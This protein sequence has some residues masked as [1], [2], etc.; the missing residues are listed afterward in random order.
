MDSQART[1]IEDPLSDPRILSTKQSLHFWSS[2]GVSNSEAPKASFSNVCSEIVTFSE[3]W[4]MY[5]TKSLLLKIHRFSSLRLHR[6]SAIWCSNS[7]DKTAIP[8]L[9]FDRGV[10]FWPSKSRIFECMQRNR[11]FFGKLT[12][13]SCKITT[14]L[15]K[16]MDSQACTPI[17][18]PRSDPQI[19]LTKQPLHVWSSIG[20][21]ISEAPTAEFSNVCSEITTFSEN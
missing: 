9:I 12:N 18:D 6:G 20:V 7:L 21:S 17:E 3:K 5:Y 4:R 14:F 16:S 8:F 10:E 19:L 13:V 15:W 1:P 2:I 11:H